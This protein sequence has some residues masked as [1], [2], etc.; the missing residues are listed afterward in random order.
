MS[1]RQVILSIGGGGFTHATNP[2]LDEFCLGFLPPKPEI[3][4]IGWANSDD[5]TRIALFHSRFE[6]LAC[7][8]SHLPLKSTAAQARNWLQ[9]KQLIYFGGGN[10]ADLVATLSANHFT[11]DLLSANRAGCVIA[12]VSAGGACWFDWI[13]SDSGGHAYQPI[14]GLSVIKGAICPHY[15]SEHRR[16]R[17]FERA[18]EAAK[19]TPAYAVD[20]GAC[21]VTIDGRVQAY[22]SA[23]S[24]RAAYSLVTQDE[25]LQTRRLEE[26]T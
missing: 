24:D 3:G 2:E 8:L 25:K 1:Q 26:F 15:S 18:V 22:F 12:G 19:G 21:L 17:H 7:S 23:H 20:D 4:Y 5:E 13:L 16:Q 11:A 10:T 6:N 14:D 9:G